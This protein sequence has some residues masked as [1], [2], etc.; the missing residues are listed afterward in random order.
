MDK[1]K[2][3]NK[4]KAGVMGADGKMRI[5]QR[6]VQKRDEKGGDSSS[7]SR[8]NR[9][10]F[11]IKEKPEFFTEIIKIG[12]V[13]KVTGGGKRMRISVFVVIGDKKGRLGL[14]SGKAVDTKVATEKAVEYAKRHMVNVRLKGNTILSEINHKFGAAKI[15]MKPASSGTGVI[16]G[17]PVRKVLEI[18]G[19]KDVLTKQIGT[20]NPIANAY[21]TVEALL[22]MK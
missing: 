21:A 19:V 4:S 6:R 7:Q 22:R 14:G 11:P 8:P 20:T 10:D 17:G 12:R 2:L 13:T 18:A 1:T 15:W 9:G 5:V 3:N 16:A